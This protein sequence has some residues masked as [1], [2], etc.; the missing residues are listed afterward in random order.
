MSKPEWCVC[1]GHKH[2]D[3]PVEPKH[4]FLDGL[5][6]LGDCPCKYPTNQEKPPPV[7]G[8]KFSD[9]FNDE[10]IGMIFPIEAKPTYR[11]L[12]KFAKA[13]DRFLPEINDDN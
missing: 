11:L 1:K 4:D 6:N 9:V 2:E 13:L 10:T 12:W 5:C 8:K 7:K 3:I